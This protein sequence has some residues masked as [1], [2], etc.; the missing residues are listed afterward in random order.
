[1]IQE[2]IF[3]IEYDRGRMRINLSDV[4]PCPKTEFKK[5]LSAVDLAADPAAYADELNG[6]IR[7]QYEAAKQRE[8]AETWIPNKKAA[9]QEAKKYAALN[10]VLVKKYDC[11]AVDAA[12]EEQPKMKKA[13]VYAFCAE[14]G[15]QIVKPYLNGYTF[16][17]V[18]Y[19]FS[20]FRKDAKD[21]WHILLSESGVQ[22]AEVYKKT[23]VIDAVRDMLPKIEQGRERENY[24]DMKARFTALMI[25]AGYMEAQQEGSSNDECAEAMNQQPHS[26]NEGNS[27]AAQGNKQPEKKTKPHR[28]SSRKR[29]AKKTQSRTQPEAQPEAQKKKD[30]PKKAFVYFE[31]KKIYLSALL[32]SFSDIYSDLYN[33]RDNHPLYHEAVNAFDEYLSSMYADIVTAFNECRQDLISS[34][35]EAAAFVIALHSIAGSDI[36]KTDRDS[37]KEEAEREALI[38]AAFSRFD[39][40]TDNLKNKYQRGFITYDELEKELIEYHLNALR[41]EAEDAEKAESAQQEAED[42]SE[43]SEAQPEKICFDREIY[44]PI[45]KEKIAAILPDAIAA[46]VTFRVQKNID[47]FRCIDEKYTVYISRMFLSGGLLY[48]YRD[49]YNTECISIEDILHIE[50][51]MNDGFR[52]AEAEEKSVPAE[53]AAAVDEEEKTLPDAV[54]EAVPDTVQ[55]KD[56]SII[57]STI[58]DRIINAFMHSRISAEEMHSLLEEAYAAAR[59]VEEKTIMPQEAAEQPQGEGNAAAVQEAAYAEENDCRAF[60][61]LREADRAAA[62]DALKEKTLAAPHNSRTH[63]SSSRKPEYM[64]SS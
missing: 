52:K 18:G 32:K 17:L 5:V 59:S 63:Y 21:L 24:K 54:Q 28:N 38:E 29:S 40:F 26:T 48:G 56:Y 27:T 9:A 39:M 49:E 4:L 14:N 6:Y 42:P 23:E 8:E 37:R 12:Q 46:K 3:S 11:S 62:Q 45:P 36:P 44:T 55:E 60:Y 50:F 47:R 31:G 7:Q 53:E 43:K 19:D 13:I 25:E 35:R 34:D 22:C 57:D 64:N 61:A 10:E 33:S 51:M 16:Q 15:K 2:G 1:M 41:Q 20:V 58:K 30:L